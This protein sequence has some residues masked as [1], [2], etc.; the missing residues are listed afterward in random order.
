MNKSGNQFYSEEIRD[1]VEVMPTKW[2]SYVS[3][4]SVVLVMVFLTLGFFIDYPETVS[5][6]VYISG[7][8]ASIRITSP[9]RGQISLLVH[10]RQL[11]HVGSEL[12]YIENAADYKDVMLLEKYCDR[13]SCSNSLDSF[14]ENLNLGSIQ[15]S[16][17]SFLRAIHKY[18]ALLDSKTYAEMCRSLDE[19]ESYSHN[20]AGNIAKELSLRKSITNLQ[21]RQWYRDS[22]LYAAGAVSKEIMEERELSLLNNMQQVRELENAQSS[23]MADIGKT[24][25][26]RAKLKIDKD[27]SLV[28]ASNNVETALNDLKAHIQEWKKTYVISS[29]VD[30]QVEYLAFLQEH[31]SVDQGMEL[32]AIKAARNNILGKM[33]IP[34]SG[35]GQVKAGQDVNVKLL[36]YPYQKY[37]FIKARIQSVSHHLIHSSNNSKYD[38]MADD[39]LMAY[40]SF[41]DGL[42]TNYGIILPCESETKGLADIVTR[43]YKLIERLFSNLRTNTSK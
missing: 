1:I 4:V 36:T 8:S 10:E 30:G 7:N 5:G 40:V 2:A 25:I 11:V 31:I 32:F 43:K 42:K 41:P 24:Q 23:A 21:K 12:A 13:F 14:P 35:A 3:Y 37:G 39:A 26:E 16:F 28:E 19:T 29:P 9:Q 20:L 27:E 22:A 17:A 6:M 34:V 15:P 33:L 38:G 18:N